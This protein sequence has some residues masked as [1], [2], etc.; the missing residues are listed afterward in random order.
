M[1]D[2]HTIDLLGLINP[3]LAAL[4]AVDQ[5]ILNAEYTE[6]ILDILL[7]SEFVNKAKDR[8]LSVTIDLVHSLEMDNIDY[9]RSAKTIIEKNSD[10]S[11]NEN[12]E[13]FRKFITDVYAFARE[14][15][16]KYLLEKISDVTQTITFLTKEGE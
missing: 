15:N 16:E 7:S 4:D 3:V 1:A 5:A 6:A 10:E 14:R 2:A 8:K 9:L 13:I 11:L 12:L